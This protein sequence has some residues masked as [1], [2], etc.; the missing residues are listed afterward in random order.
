MPG[1][2]APG[3]AAPGAEAVAHYPALGQLAHCAAEFRG[4]WID[5][6]VCECSSERYRGLAAEVSLAAGALYD[7][8]FDARR[9]PRFGTGD[10]VQHVRHRPADAAA[11]E[12]NDIEAHKFRRADY[13]AL[14]DFERAE[15]TLRRA[16]RAQVAPPPAAVRRRGMF[17]G[18]PKYQPRFLDP[19]LRLALAHHEAYTKEAAARAVSSVG[20]H[21]QWG[22][23][24]LRRCRLHLEGTPTTRPDGTW[25]AV[26][27]PAS[28]AARERPDA[29]GPRARR[30]A[31]V[32][33]AFRLSQPTRPR[34]VASSGSTERAATGMVFVARFGQ[35]TDD[36][37]GAPQQQP[38][39]LDDPARTPCRR[40]PSHAPPLGSIQAPILLDVHT[41]SCG[42]VFPKAH[43]FGAP[44][45]YSEARGKQPLW[46]P[47]PHDLADAVVADYVSSVRAM[48]SRGPR[49]RA[50]NS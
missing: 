43:R 45:S 5:V 14:D 50:K 39:A 36:R 40:D 38:R 37:F 31:T 27:A 23:A 6:A 47:P 9:L 1:A 49:A 22:A 28:A 11:A 33:T 26:I 3:A 32:A 35:T 25:G 29:G 4:R 13:E 24:G 44:P 16:A 8:G 34:N 46:T 41:Q 18:L 12:A 15:R 7:A 30:P 42:H 10:V 21:A 48:R 2:A 19:A 20:H 17:D